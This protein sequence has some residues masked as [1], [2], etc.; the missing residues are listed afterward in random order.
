MHVKKKYDHEYDVNFPQ[1]YLNHSLYFC[2]KWKTLWGD[3]FKSLARKPSLI[4]KL[5]TLRVFG[6]VVQ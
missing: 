4:F 1:A 5:Q 3:N 2:T 6:S